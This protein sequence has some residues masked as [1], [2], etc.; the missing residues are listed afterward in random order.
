[1]AQKD[2]RFTFEALT[3][4]DSNNQLPP[5]FD[6]VSFHF[7]ETL[8]DTFRL[9]V[10]LVSF[11]EQIDFAALLDQPVLFSIWQG[12]IAVR[13]VQGLV[14]SFYQNDTGF[15]RTRYHAVV[16]PQLARLKLCSDWRIFQQQNAAE[17][18]QDIL[19]AN[20]LENRSIHTTQEHVAREYCVQAGVT[21]FAF[22]QRLL[23][24]EGFVYCFEQNYLRITDVIQTFGSLVD[25]PSNEREL[26]QNDESHIT[27]IIYQPNAGGDQQRPAIKQFSYSEHVRTAQQTQRDYTFKHPRYA[28][29]HSIHGHNLEHQSTEYEQYNYPGRYKQDAVGAPFTQTK[30]LSIRN[31]TQIA[32]ATGD[33]ARI[34]LGKAFQLSG[35]HK[36]NLNILWRPVQIE[37]KGTQHTS[38]EEEAAS[39]HTSTSYKQIAQLVPATADW[40][41]PIPEQFFFKGPL[42][43]HI[44]G[45]DGEEIYTDEFG[46]VKVQFPW[47]RVNS[48]NEHSS[49]WIRVA[50]NW[51]GAGWGHMTLP[52]VGQEVIV[53]FLGGDE[54]QPIII[55]RTYDAQHPV[56]YKLPALKTQATIKSKEHKGT[57]Y[58]ELLID[59]TT[60]E[61][62]TQ[63]HSTHG[64]TQL[65][66]G[67]LT[68]PRASDGSGEHRGDGFELRTDEWGAIRAGKG[69]YISADTRERAKG[70]QLDLQEALQQLEEARSITASLQEAAKVAKAELADL[71]TQ[72]TLLSETF[73]E[74]KQA[75]VLINAP[76]GVGTTSLKSVQNHA[77]ENLIFTSGR[78][79]DFSAMRK[80]TINA[81]HAISLFSARQGIKVIANKGDVNLQAQNDAMQLSS[82]QDMTLQSVLGKVEVCAKQQLVLKCGGAY[83]KLEN[84]NIELGCPGN[85]L[86]K[87]ASLKSLPPASMGA[88]SPESAGPFEEFF[89]VT[90]QRTGVILPFVRYRVTTSDGST[91]TGRTNKDGNTMMIHTATPQEI[92]LEILE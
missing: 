69:I 32:K 33:D 15:R 58:N 31:D 22:I 87:S 27:E 12:G 91:Y 47:D 80:F 68:H 51:A 66:M 50:Q 75:A 55:G 23:A 67:Y 7:Q 59:D 83:I 36:Q 81:G 38:S 8:N 4:T 45:E 41:A 78:Q 17:I 72:K 74:L 42:I 13:H 82:Y 44:T 73:E 35:H 5:A 62:K 90:D 65:T 71:Q 3:S 92:T 9:E 54:S 88:G 64:A 11:D 60:G 77:G 19:K 6:V 53:D 56:P 57:G 89:T 86:F 46:R 84:G 40:K 61:I 25:L 34:Q 20:H 43:A 10:E 70:L 26:S 21:D 18:V 39:A 85:I 2:I 48:H 16:E 24:E 63:L 49:C 79:T 29:E 1:M 28:Q 52:R 76:E 14:S 30:L 37:H